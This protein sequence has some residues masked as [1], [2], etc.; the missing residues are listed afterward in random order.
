MFSIFV[1]LSLASNTIGEGVLLPCSLSFTDN[2]ETISLFCI[3][4]KVTIN[5]CFFSIFPLVSSNLFSTELG[6]Y[7]MLARVLFMGI[8][9]YSWS[10][11]SSFWPDKNCRSFSFPS[12]DTFLILRFCELAI[13]GPSWSKSEVCTDDFAE[14]TCEMTIIKIWKFYKFVYEKINATF[15]C[16]FITQELAHLSEPNV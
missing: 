1:L 12:C 3:P 15:C 5:L 16:N 2:L 11:V 4:S 6:I 13:L 7:S 9:I 8:G 14:F 10:E